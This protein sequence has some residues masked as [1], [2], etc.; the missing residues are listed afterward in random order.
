MQI[1]PQCFNCRHLAEGAPM[2]CS[3][4]PNGIPMEIL[5]NQVDHKKPYEGDNGIRFETLPPEELKDA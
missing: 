1:Q 4:F 5:L 3:A 2:H